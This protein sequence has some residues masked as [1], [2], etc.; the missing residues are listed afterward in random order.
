MR[1]ALALLALAACTPGETH[2]T[3]D[4]WPEGLARLAPLSDGECPDLS[5]PG[6]STFSSGGKERRVHVYF[7]EHK[8]ADMPVAFFW[9]PLGA[10]A[11]MITN[12]ID[13]GVLAD[14]HDM[15]FVIPQALSEEPYEWGFYA[16]D[17]MYDGVLYDDLRTCLSQELAVDLE[18]VSTMGMSAGGLWSSWLTVRRADTLSTAYV[19]SGGTGQV[20]YYETPA[21]PIPVLVMWGGPD[22][23]Y[24]LGA[25]TVDFEASSIHFSEHLQADGHFVVE[26]LHDDGHTIPLDALGSFPAWLKAHRFGK[27]SPYASGDLGDLPRWCYV[28]G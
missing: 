7:P 11:N 14:R 4:D 16:D 8:P 18:R 13:F 23:T 3:A 21:E 20:V 22:D 9:H 28:P 24:S 17:G 5:E 10:T 12:I 1:T 15:A 2:D 19:M 27:E 26:C 6:R 25:R